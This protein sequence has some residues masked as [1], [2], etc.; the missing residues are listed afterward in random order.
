MQAQV[1]VKEQERV[2]MQDPLAT[3][4]S[5][6][7]ILALCCA[8]NFVPQNS[9]ASNS[10]PGAIL[11]L[12]FVL[13]FVLQLPLASNSSPWDGLCGISWAT[14]GA[15]MELPAPLGLPRS[16]QEA[17]ERFGHRSDSDPIPIRLRSGTDP[18]LQKCAY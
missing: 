9:L 8:L 15:R 17:V 6:R 3:N 13:N 12:S 4:A 10:S 11:A 18:A 5:P 2:E 14:V 16:R 1:L 7:A